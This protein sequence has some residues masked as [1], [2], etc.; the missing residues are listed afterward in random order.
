MLPHPARQPEYIIIIGGFKN[1]ASSL[2][3]GKCEGA[4][5]RETYYENNAG[6]DFRNITRIIKWSASLSNQGITVSKK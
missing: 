1:A 2:I 6:E 3:E 4:I 5:L